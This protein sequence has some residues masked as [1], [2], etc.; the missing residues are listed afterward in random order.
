MATLMQ[1]MTDLGI[2]YISLE[3][4]SMDKGQVISATRL[5]ARFDGAAENEFS[6]ALSA[7][8]RVRIGEVWSK[9]KG[10]LGGLI[11]GTLAALVGPLFNLQVTDGYIRMPINEISR[12]EDVPPGMAEG[13]AGQIAANEGLN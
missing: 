6:N 12:L 10:G 11:V 2:D 1:R 8:F 7:S 3:R 9:L 4:F 5:P 13:I